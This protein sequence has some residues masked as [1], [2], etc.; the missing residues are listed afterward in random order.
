MKKKLSPYVRIPGQ[1]ADA[2][3]SIIKAN[4][5]DLCI[6]LLN[7]AKKQRMVD[8]QVNKYK[9]NSRLCNEFSHEEIT[10]LL[11]ETISQCL[12]K[13]DEF[14]KAKRSGKKQE[15]KFETFGILKGYFI[16]AFLNNVSKLYTKHKTEKR[17]AAKTMVYL[18]SS[19]TDENS[20]KNTLESLVS[21]NPS[22]EREYKATLDLF[23]RHL[24]SYDK[25]VNESLRN[26]NAKKSKF[27]KLAHMFVCLINPRYKGDQD[28]IKK[29]LG[30]SDHVFKENRKNL[31]SKLQ[32]DFPEMGKEALSYV[33]ERDSSQ[34]GEMKEKEKQKQKAIEYR[35]NT[36]F[37]MQT[38]TPNK[39]KKQNTYKKYS[40]KIL[41]EKLQN[42]KWV[43]DK[44]KEKVIL[45]KKNVVSFDEAK[46]KLKAMSQKEMSLFKKMASN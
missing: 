23:I 26:K 40:Q 13:F 3:L 9:N 41:L 29:L 22:D 36:Y 1:I 18:E 42:G 8:Y 45:D 5:N 15:L 19:S 39:N 28:K 33:I 34:V 21:Y 31:I 35:V 27:S 14:K 43:V 12:C 32:S 44:E 46:E 17:A 30:M 25:K 7:V 6:E 20:S 10:G 4:R 2:N 37:S 11:Y 16:N 24:R 38:V